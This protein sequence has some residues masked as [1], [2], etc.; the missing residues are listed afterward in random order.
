MICMGGMDVQSYSSS[1]SI[2]VGVTSQLVG[3]VNGMPDSML[4]LTSFL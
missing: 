3:V 1:L 4:C 2:V